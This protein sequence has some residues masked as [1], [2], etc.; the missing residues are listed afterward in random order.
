MKAVELF[1][2]V[3]GFRLACDAAGIETVFAN[4]W[5]PGIKAQHAAKVYRQRFGPQ[6]PL[7]NV[8]VSTV[9]A[10]EVP[11]HD[12]L[13]AGFPCQDYSAATPNAKGMDGKKGVLWWQIRRLLDVKRPEWVLLE[14]VDRLLVSPSKQRGRDFAVV[15]CCLRELGY[16]V[17]WQVVNASEWGVPQAR[18]RV[19]VVASRSSDPRAVLGEAFPSRSADLVEDQLPEGL[20][21]IS[22]T[23]GRAFKPAGYMDRDGRLQH[24]KVHVDGIPGP[25]LGSVLQP[26]PGCEIDDLD[27]WRYVKGAKDEARTAKNGYSYRFREG[28]LSFPDDPSR[29]ARTILTS[30]G[31]KAPNR[32]THVVQDPETGKL[33]TLRPV[34][35]ERIQGFPDGWTEGVPVGWR[36][37]C[38]GNAVAVPVVTR[39]AQAIAR[40]AGSTDRGPRIPCSSSESQD[41]AD[42]I[43]A[44]SA[45]G[46]HAP[47]AR[48]PTLGDWS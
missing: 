14:N 36:F 17:A 24:G 40:Q 43:K 18:R 38:M 15:L 2:G 4:Q 41:L 34:E 12:L 47:A 35:A 11:D 8:D 39:I 32:S 25:A 46:I 31:R 37:K 10:E 28:A 45:A 20:D 16:A 9:Q 30:E 21:V 7:F 13:T 22:E 5:E 1:A 26:G 33:R 29:P 44:T 3:G 48:Q 6:G 19:Y 27:R 23:W 42:G